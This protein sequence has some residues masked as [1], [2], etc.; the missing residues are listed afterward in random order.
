MPVSK[1]DNWLYP[2]LICI[3]C[4]I[5]S[6]FNR[7]NPF[8]MTYMQWD[9][10]LYQYIGWQMLEGQFPYRDIFDHKGP[11]IYLWNM[12][13]YGLHPM[14]GQWFLEFI[15]LFISGLLALKIGTRFISPAL[16]TLIIGIIFFNIPE[17]NTIGNLEN[18]AVLFSYIALDIFMEY[19]TTNRIAK[20]KIM[21]FGAVVALLLFLKPVYL[22][23]P[24]ALI[25]CIIIKLL[26][27]KQYEE[28]L[29]DILYFLVA[30]LGI[31]AAIIGWLNYHNALQDFWNC[32]I[33]FNLD[34]TKHWQ[35]ANNRNVVL[36]A[37]LRNYFLNITAVIALYLG[38]TLKRYTQT[39]RTLII[40]LI[41]AVLL[42]LVGIILPN[43]PFL[44]YLYI[45]YPLTFLMSVIA[46][47]H[48]Q[49][50]QI[51]FIILSTCFML[52]GL[53]CTS[54]IKKNVSDRNAVQAAAMINTLLQKD[55][56]FQ[57]LGWDMGRLH[58]LSGRPAATP[59]VMTGM[60]DRIHQRYLYTLIKNTRPPLVA[61][62]TY[63]ENDFYHK[64]IK[65]YWKNFNRD[66]VLYS[67]RFGYEIYILRD[68]MPKVQPQ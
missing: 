56:T 55:E 68:K 45:L 44:H 36:Y 59:Y 29:T 39:E 40:T 50:F 31:S 48:W 42:N 52:S 67:N 12:L 24:T 18:L 61:I 6:L 46:I 7:Q 26:L 2:A 3:I 20:S 41:F 51:S 58:L 35:K 10:S 23:T 9:T 60:Y 64:L 38:I 11:I 32:Y 57:T 5:V 53:Y 43:N 16:C 8:N 30:F 28:L 14:L 63:P 54:H 65:A 13:G 22:A 19:I 25:I 33:E 62:V 17:N 15:A 4:F 47:K 34:Y 37:E 27:K 66:Y 1:K 21:V 49:K